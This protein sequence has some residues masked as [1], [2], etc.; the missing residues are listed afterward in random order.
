MLKRK[1]EPPPWFL[2]EPSAELREL[3]EAIGRAVGAGNLSI[4]VGEAL[5]HDAIAHVPGAPVQFPPYGP[6]LDSRFRLFLIWA[7]RDAAR[8]FARDLDAQGFA[9]RK[10]VGPVLISRGRRDEVLAVAE[11]AGPDLSR[12]EMERIATEESAWWLRTRGA[13]E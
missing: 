4:G 13:A 3:A 10:A 8:E 7:M 9:V 1:W 5:I 2:R 11:A 6:W 12:A